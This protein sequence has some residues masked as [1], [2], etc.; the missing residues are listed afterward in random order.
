MTDAIRTANHYHDW[1]FAS[2]EQAILPGVALEVGSGHGKYSR[3]IV[4]HV[5]KL[6]VSDI[7]PIAVERI[8]D[9][10]A[11]FG[12]QVE[13]LTMAGIDG[14]KIDG[15]VDNVILVNLL[16]HIADDAAL[17]KDCRDVLRPGGALIL[18]VP[19]FQALFSKMDDHAGHHRRYHR[20]ELVRLVQDCGFDVDS[21]RY[22]N[23][24]GFF[25]WYANKL[26]K[27]EINSGTTNAQVS[28]YNR[29]IPYLKYADRL[30]PMVGQS[31]VVVA[32]R[33]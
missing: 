16:E 10:L 29:L 2:F 21:N 19:A 15:P 13:C 24:V 32:R 30:L 31:L 22:F 12:E 1:V 28:L 27:S 3:K 33:R 14:E 7:D 20:Q 11:E 18:F 5:D 6:Y 23:A 4:R 17:L 26:L 9:E 25:G 8:R